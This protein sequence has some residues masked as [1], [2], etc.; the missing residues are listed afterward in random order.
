MP[1]C[2][3]IFFH[4]ACPPTKIN[5][6]RKHECSH[7]MPI[8]HTKTIL[9]TISGLPLHQLPNDIGNPLHGCPWHS[10]PEILLDYQ[11]LTYAS[12]KR[13][14]ALPS[15]T[16]LETTLHPRPYNARLLIPVRGEQQ[17]HGLPR[18]FLLTVIRK[19][20]AAM[21]RNES[22]FCRYTLAKI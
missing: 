1:V 12:R 17:E 14:V 18:E 21:R 5:C 22:G 13:S 8:P 2:A 4:S 7:L 6:G 15:C 3:I 9:V 11:P 10:S 16:V 19:R 20:R